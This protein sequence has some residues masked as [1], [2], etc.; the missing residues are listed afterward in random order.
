MTVKL[1]GIMGRDI[2]HARFFRGQQYHALQMQSEMG[3]R[4]AGHMEAAGI[5]HSCRCRTVMVVNIYNS[6]A[7]AW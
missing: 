2:E 7:S 4:H 6:V 1:Q 3:E 5:G